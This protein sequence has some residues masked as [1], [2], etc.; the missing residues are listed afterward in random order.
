VKR[1]ALIALLAVWL[2][3]T[4]CTDDGRTEVVGPGAATQSVAIDVRPEVSVDLATVHEAARVPPRAAVLEPAD[5][6]QVAAWVRRET[7][8]QRPVLINFFA[9]YCEPCARELP[10]LLETAATAT[11]VTFAGVH[12]AESIARGDQMIDE[13]GIDL[14]T[15]TDP[16]MDIIAE[17]GGRGLP[18]TVVFDAEGHL[19][20]RVFGEL[21]DASLDALLT[22]ARRASGR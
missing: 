15:F 16:S 2:G 3:T 7:A 20:G 6:T 4:A 18:Y 14:P 11:D 12:T 10:L 8:S 1:H 19:A 22:E 21:T 9:S 5:W 17:V 13:F